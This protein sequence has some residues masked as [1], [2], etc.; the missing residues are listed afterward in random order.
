MKQLK[1]ISNEKNEFVFNYGGIVQTEVTLVMTNPNHYAK[2]ILHNEKNLNSN[3]FGFR[4]SII[5]VVT[6]EGTS[7]DTQILC[8]EL[9]ILTDS[10]FEGTLSMKSNRIM[11]RGETD[12][13]RLN[14]RN[15]ATFSLNPGTVQSFHDY[16]YYDTE[17]TMLYTEFCDYVDHLESLNFKKTPT[18]YGIR[19][20]HEFSRYMVL[21][22][23]KKAVN[24]QIGFDNIAWIDKEPSSAK[25][26]TLEA[27]EFG[28]A[29]LSTDLF[30][31]SDIVRNKT[32]WVRKSTE[33]YPVT[34]IIQ[35]QKDR[36]NRFIFENVTFFAGDATI[37]FENP[38]EEITIIDSILP[39]L[40][41]ENA[42]IVISHSQINT[43]KIKI[44]A[45][46]KRFENSEITGIE[47][48]F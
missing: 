44:D 26:Y 31:D 33:E 1:L 12:I 29:F 2:M 19:A 28:Q 10:I 38:P 40:L 18:L 6:T 8:D 46:L 23:N 47:T 11:T 17:R 22:D 36:S 13:K 32:I 41:A 14:L 7:C 16:R 25:R 20:L 27:N 42:S 3:Y 21:L 45:K 48:M 24:L 34:I 9:V 37:K 15:D 35:N 39:N 43:L 4:S 30:G 5:K